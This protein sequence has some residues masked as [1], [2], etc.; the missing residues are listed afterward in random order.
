MRHGP[1]CPVK[2]TIRDVT[3]SRALDAEYQNLTGRPMLIKV[4][5]SCT[6][7]AAGEGA[8]IDGQYGPIFGSP[9]IAGRS[10]IMSGPIR[11]QYS[12]LAYAVPHGEYYKVVSQKSGGASVNLTAWIETE[13]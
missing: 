13:L 4:T 12:F 7:V 8:W 9:F 10:G 1:P 6:T 3:A 11:Q 5:V 2:A